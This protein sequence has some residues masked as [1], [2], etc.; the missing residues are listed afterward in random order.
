MTGSGLAAE[1]GPRT[2][3][4]GRAFGGRVAPLVVAAIAVALVV[5]AATRLDPVYRQV[6]GVYASW[7]LMPLPLEVRYE[8]DSVRRGF[9]GTPAAEEQRDTRQEAADVARLSGALSRV[10]TDV[11]VRSWQEGSGRTVAVGVVEVE[12]AAALA[13]RLLR[14][15]G[16]LSRGELPRRTIARAWPVGDRFVV[17]L[18]VT[19]PGTRA[20]RVAFA[21][22][23]A[24]QVQAS[25]GLARVVW[26]EAL[27]LGPFLLV[28]VLWG[29]AYVLWIVLWLAFTLL[30]K[31]PVYLLVLL[32]LSLLGLRRRPQ[33]PMSLGPERD[34]PLR[35]LA[36][37][38][39]VVD[40]D[41]RELHGGPG[42]VAWFTAV[43]LALAVA[44]P[45][46]TR[47]LWTASLVWGALGAAL[48]LVWWGRGQ[49]DTTARW[50][51]W[52]VAG[53]MAVELADALFGVGPGLPTDGP[54]ALAVAVL[55][56]LGA[57]TL[58]WR[59]GA[60]AGSLPGYAAWHAD[61]DLRSAVYLV[62]LGGIALAGGALFLGSNGDLDAASQLASKSIAVA[63]L[64]VVPFVGRRVR[65][66][67]EA[68][69]REWA[70]EREVAEVLLL[71]S[72]VDDGLQ[73]P[74]RPRARRGLERF[75]PARRE[76]FEDVVVRAFTQLGPVVAIA[77]PGTGQTELGASRDLIVGSD[78]LTAVKEEM[79][80]AAHVVVILG[81]G[82]GLVL[83][84]QALSEL[85]LLDRVCLVVPP[86]EPDDVAERLRTGTAA[87]D[88]EDGWG[89]LCP[90]GAH[91]FTGEEV[92]GLLG[93]G[94]RRFVAISGQREATAYLRLGAFLAGRDPGQPV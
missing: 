66:A 41:S 11:T 59:R 58:A 60:A 51:R 36:P 78:W 5:L 43:V 48:A 57:V 75:I 39:E 90:D 54:A 35:G 45:A 81:R 16:A 46:L 37:R 70:R 56:V 28:P 34:D 24:E 71:R 93:S 7:Q 25:A 63:G 67:R 4:S 92:L 68:A 40:L 94:E 31:L 19:A 79:A 65:A 52:A 61:L 23:R 27:S 83:E 29:I 74:S 85:E 8:L 20:E 9:T 84:L 88:G 76:L 14:T 62:G 2:R 72:F 53:A 3:R 10:S 89:L 38:V 22:A 33:P 21:D 47:S 50:A 13:D 30:V 15:G 26:W 86:V 80:G 1:S 6:P 42:A 18:T 55:L 49:K 77:R 12:E 82:E 64:A 17:A 91:G 73:V 87:V 32:P 44:I 69:R